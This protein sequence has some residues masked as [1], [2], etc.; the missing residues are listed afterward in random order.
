MNEYNINDYNSF[1][2]AKQDT[3]NVINS[4]ENH[5]TTIEE[6]KNIISNKEIF[7]GPIADDCE[8]NINTIISNTTNFVEKLLSISTFITN[9][10]EIYKAGDNAA[11]DVISGATTPN[12]MTSGNIN[13]TT[14]N[15]IN[16]KADTLDYAKH[17]DKDKV[18]EIKNADKYSGNC[19]GFAMTQAWGL[20]TN[21]KN[22]T[23]E[24]GLNYRGA[25]NFAKYNNDNKEEFLKRV[26]QELVNN[27]PVVIQVNGNRNGTS[28]HYVT[29]VGFKNTVK[30]ASQLKE[31]DLLIIDSYDGKL[32]TMDQSGSRF[33]TTGA[34]CGKSYS[35]Y[36]LRYIK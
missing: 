35:G 1:S 7:M 31:T 24:D 23:A 13:G 25:S 9:A 26:Y 36:Q 27:K 18:S 22:Y 5:K 14:Y 11:T 16:G 17:I 29:A 2:N 8:K 6:C 34:K 19:L 4:L 3:Y 20:Y 12:N 30:G 33:L 28:R 21:N 32:E 10:E 15:L